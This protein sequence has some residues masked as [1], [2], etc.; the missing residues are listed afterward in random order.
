MAGLSWWLLASPTFAVREVVVSGSLNQTV[1]EALT[2]L[3]GSNIVLLRTEAIEHEL[4]QHQSSIRELRIIKGF[5]STLKIAVAVRAPIAAWQ[6]GSDHFF[7]D[8]DGVAFQSEGELAGTADGLPVV[9]DERAQPV[10]LGAPLVSRAF[11]AFVGALDHDFSDQIGNA[12]TSLS[13]GET[14]RQLTVHTDAG[15]L[16]RFDT[17]RSLDPQLTALR[18]VL[19]RSRSEIHEYVDL[20]VEGKVFY[21]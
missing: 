6:S 18:Q 11:V 15:F 12:I 9:T 1:A 13:V 16:I 2:R 10:T 21:K 5:P 7:I 20:R 17:T 4:P 19:D 14:T 8:R 3:K